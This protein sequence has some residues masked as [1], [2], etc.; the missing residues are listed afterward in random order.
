MNTSNAQQL[1]SGSDQQG[2]KKFKTMNLGDIKKEKHTTTIESSAFN[3]GFPDFN[4]MNPGMTPFPMFMFNQML[5][6]A[7]QFPGG[8]QFP[9]VMG[10]QSTPPIKQSQGHSRNKFLNIPM[11]SLNDYQDIKAIKDKFECLRDVNDPKF[12]PENIKDAD[13]FIIRSSNDDDFHKAVKYGIWSSSQKNNHA[14]NEAYLNGQRKDPKRPVFLFF[15][16]VSSD[17]YIGVAQMNSEIDFT[18]SFSFWWEM[19]KWSGVMNLK[20]IYV[21]DVNYSNFT[22]VYYMNKPVTHHRDGTRLDYETGM[23]MLKIFDQSKSADSIFDEFQLM[24]N[25]EEKLRIERGLLD[26]VAEPTKGSGGYQGHYKDS[27]RSYRDRGDRD[28]DGHY[29]RKNKYAGD[30]QPKK[31]D[32][33]KKDYFYQEREEKSEERNPGILIQKKST[34]SKKSKQSKEY[35]RK[36]EKLVEKPETGAETIQDTFTE[37][38]DS[39][40]LDFDVP[41]SDS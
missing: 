26:S 7:M 5:S 29:Y 15:T 31:K 30:Y 34:K 40:N 27:H 1:I 4:A 20:W 12:R 37:K 36:D 9:Y 6:G 14:L 38:K 33:F 39:Q 17:Q 2:E 10:Q 13:F 25:R 35:K 3:P 41:M 11:V 8:F 18:K 24:D 19:T 23:K 32:S 21:R 28:R 22:N 16:V